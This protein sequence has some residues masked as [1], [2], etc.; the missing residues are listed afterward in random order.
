MGDRYA[1]E[2]GLREIVG[3][4]LRL[5]EPMSR[6]TTI[7]VGGPARYLAVPGNVSQ[8]VGLV[9]FA[10]A[11][12]IEYVV[13][14]KG[15]NLVVRD[16]GYDGL[17][18][19]MGSQISRVRLNRT[20]VSAEGG[21][22]LSRLARR[23]TSMGRAGLEFAVGI[24]GSVGGAVVMNAGAYGWQIADVLGCVKLVDEGG[25][26]VALE[27]HEIEF[28]YRKT[29]IPPSS[30]VL[31]ATLRCPPGKIDEETYR[32]SLSR[33]DTQP[34]SERTFGSTF[35]NPP[36]DYAARLIDACGLKGTRRGGAMVSPKHANFIVN[37]E[38]KATAKDVEDL[39][40]LVRDEVRQKHGVILEPEVIVIGHR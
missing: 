12:G 26:L 25:A 15:S 9:K 37:V 40:D 10:R 23:L 17:V 4:G 7:G 19:K 11:A 21:A 5:G 3:A 18:I 14:G 35:V 27:R 29:S 22:A 36:N 34:I 28:G 31:S 20:T 2:R 1:T 30:V 13:L 38:G 33:K 24:P 39:M 16:G 6:H 32:K 8:V